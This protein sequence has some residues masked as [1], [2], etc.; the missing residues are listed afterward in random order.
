LG[1]GLQLAGFS[2]PLC[3]RLSDCFNQAVQEA[4][5]LRASVLQ[6]L[7]LRF[8]Q[9]AEFFGNRHLS[10]DFENRTARYL[11]KLAQ[12]PIRE[13][14]LTFGDVACDRDGGAAQLTR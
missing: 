12:F 14:A 2:E 8:G 11:E 13:P 4:A 7:G 9:K 5:K 6:L 3:C 10:F 1:F